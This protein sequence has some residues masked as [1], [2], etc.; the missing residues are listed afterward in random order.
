MHIYIHWNVLTVS[1]HGNKNSKTNFKNH[2]GN[3]YMAMEC[4]NMEFMTSY[5][6]YLNPLL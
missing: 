3:G 4:I 1:L 2:T 6:T 5:L